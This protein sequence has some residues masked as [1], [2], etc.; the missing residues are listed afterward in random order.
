MLYNLIVAICKNRG[1]GLNGEL[2]WHFTEDLRYF[3]KLTKGRGNNAIIMG[4]NTCTDTFLPGRD[5]LVLTS[6]KNNFDKT[7]DDGHI[8][9]KFNSI[10]DIETFCNK[11]KYDQVWIIGGASI[12]KQF[13]QYMMVN[14]CYVTMIDMEYE[15]DT[16]FPILPEDEWKIDHD[17]TYTLIARGTNIRLDFVEY[18]SV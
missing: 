16:F 15:C 17:K 14:R 9:K 8:W 3:S 12:Y 5:N 18:Y 4:K 10:A 7:M 1:I 11:M 13:L 6:I 2:P